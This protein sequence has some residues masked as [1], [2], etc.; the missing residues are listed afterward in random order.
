M[1]SFTVHLQINVVIRFSL[2]FL[3]NQEME[4]VNKQNYSESVRMITE[5]L[6]DS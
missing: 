2:P 4:F 5:I 6:R 1:I 3:V